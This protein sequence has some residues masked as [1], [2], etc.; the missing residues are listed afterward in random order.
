MSGANRA[1]LG[2]RRAV[3]QHV[4]DA[5]VVVEPFE[6]AQPRHGAGG[7]QVQRRRAMAG[8][9]DVVRVAER[10]RQRGSR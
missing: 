6:M 3:E 1:V 9:V 10:C 5:H 7:V 4:L 8:E 2:H